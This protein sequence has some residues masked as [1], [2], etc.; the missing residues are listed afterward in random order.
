V[1]WNSKSKS[2]KEETIIFISET[3]IEKK[4]LKE[5]EKNPSLWTKL[6][7]ISGIN[8]N[9]NLQNFKEEKTEKILI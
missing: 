5:I 9:F 6:S 8:K 1:K 3:E 4:K 2:A 7:K